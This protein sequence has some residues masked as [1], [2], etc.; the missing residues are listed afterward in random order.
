MSRRQADG[1]VDTHKANEISSNLD[2]P[3]S[4]TGKALDVFF[5]EIARVP[6]FAFL[7]RASI[8]EEYRTGAIDHALLLAITGIACLVI[9]FGPGMQENGTKYIDAAQALIVLDL[10][11]PTITKIQALILIIQHRSF[12]RQFAT[13]FMLM[14]LAARS[15]LGL[16]LNYE[17]NRLHF[18]AQESCRR[19]LWSLYMLDTT[20]AAGYNDFTLFHEGLIHVQLPCQDHNFQ[21][22]IPQ[23]AEYLDSYKTQSSLN[24]SKDT[25][26]PS[27][28]VIQAL[29]LRQR[30]LQYTKT[31]GAEPPQSISTSVGAF[32]FELGSYLDRLPQ[33]FRLSAYNFRLHVHLPTFVAYI[34]IHLTWLGV[35]CILYRLVLRGLKEAL[36]ST[37]IQALDSGF[38]EACETKCLSSARSMVELFETTLRLSSDSV[39]MDIDLAVMAY[40]CSRILVY[41]FRNVQVNMTREEIEGNLETCQELLKSKFCESD[42]VSAIREDLVSLITYCFSPTG[43][44]GSIDE[45]QEQTATGSSGEESPHILSKHSL[46]RQMDLTRREQSNL[47]P[48]EALKGFRDI[49][50]HSDFEAANP[51]TT[52]PPSNGNVYEDDSV[53]A[54]ILM[55]ASDSGGPFQRSPKGL[56]HVD[57]ILLDLSLPDFD[58]GSASWIVSDS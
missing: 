14:S 17:N 48:L 1:S 56:G 46:I 50:D 21:M 44:D 31:A 3:P 11:N 25:Q 22:D 30:I 38:R 27:A 20:I 10:N 7:H 6:V 2:L 29:S 13:V 34:K 26:S 18:V 58:I 9:E 24:V 19:A 28:L 49:A 5:D 37:A 23:A 57:S 42:A 36:P 39:I 43:N 4:L 40:Q 45:A 8:M 52:L 35:N 32:D 41:F 54:R 33:S 51:T 12:S 53:A 15:A 16:R 47:R 55:G